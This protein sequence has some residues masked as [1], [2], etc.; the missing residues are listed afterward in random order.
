VRFGN[1]RRVT[2]ISPI[3]G[4]NRGQ[5]ID[6]YYIENFLMRYAADIHSDVLEVAESRYTRRF[7]RERVTKSDVLHVR[8]GEPGVTIVADLCSNT[9]IASNRFDCIILTQ[10]LQHIYDGRAAIRTLYRI[11][12]PAGVLLATLPGISQISRYD[13]DRWG[14]YWRFTTLSARKLFEESFQA[15]NVRVEAHGNVLAASAFLYGLTVEELRP[16]ELDH[17]DPDYEMLITVR[18]VKLEAKS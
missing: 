5:G 7:G 13:M 2:P 17:F 3:F 8:A 4:L 12:K 9:D 16:G 11:L 18:A 6:R 1:L 10:T 15:T 14:D